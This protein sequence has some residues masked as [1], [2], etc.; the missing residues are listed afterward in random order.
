MAALHVTV[1][2]CYAGPLFPL[3]P[4]RGIIALNVYAPPVQLLEHYARVHLNPFGSGRRASRQC[5]LYVNPL[6]VMCEAHRTFFV[7]WVL[8]FVPLRVG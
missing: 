4:A 2:V 1:R 8:A 3:F 7:R 5:M 6:V